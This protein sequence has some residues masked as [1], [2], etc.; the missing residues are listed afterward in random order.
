MYIIDQ[1]LLSKVLSKFRCRLQ[2]L[3]F[4]T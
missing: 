3:R 2:Q 1:N 4:S